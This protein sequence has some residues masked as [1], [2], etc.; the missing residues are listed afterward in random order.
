MRWEA[1]RQGSGYRKLQLAQ[2]SFW[3]AY[4]LHFPKGASVPSHMDPVSG[5]RHY[6]LNVLL[7]GQDNFKAQQTDNVWRLGPFTLFRPDLVK[8]H[9]KATDRTRL[10]LSLGCAL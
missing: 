8:H 6:R 3:D 5:K 7:C 4:L 9:V 2:G 1:G 10:V